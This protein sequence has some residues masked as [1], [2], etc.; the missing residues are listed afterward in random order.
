[1]KYQLLQLTKRNDYRFMNYRFAKEHGF[2]LNDYELVYEGE[3][4]DNNN[5]SEVLENLFTKFN[6]NRPEDFK[7]HSMSMS[8]IV[9]LN[10]QKF[11]CDS[12][13]FKRV[14]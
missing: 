9:V 1:M 11:Y 10:G 3:I 6:I 7:G 4:K 2:N 12:I 14:D 5:Y 8:D 13:G